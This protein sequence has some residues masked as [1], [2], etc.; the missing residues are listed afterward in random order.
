MESI[1][2][3]KLPFTCGT[4]IYISPQMAQK[5]ESLASSSDIWALGIIL[6]ILLTGKIPFQG[7]YDKDLFRKIQ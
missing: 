4:P 2:E 3:S 7:A 6:Y 1:T 5:K